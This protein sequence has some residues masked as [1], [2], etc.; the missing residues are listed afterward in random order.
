MRLV[1][2]GGLGFLGSNMICY[3]LSKYPSYKITNIDSVTYASNFD[4]LKEVENNPNYT[5]VKGNICDATLVDGLVKDSDVVI[6]FAA[7]SHVDRS[8]TGPGIF[9]QTNVVGTQVLLDACIKYNKHLHQIGTD[10]TM[11]DLPLNTPEKFTE[12]T[13]YNPSSPYS[14][15]KAA[16]DHLVMAY[17]RTYGLKCTLSGSS[18]NYGMKQH[19]EKL[20]PTIITNAMQGKNI[21]V[22]GDGKNVRDWVHTL[23]HAFA[24]DLII[25]RGKSGQRYLIGGN[26]ERSNLEVVKQILNI[27]GKPES[28]ISH[29][30][31]RKGHDLRYAVDASKIE[32]ELGW[33]RQYTFDDGIRETIA[34][35][36]QHA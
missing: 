34:W 33:S 12:N 36:L 13:P 21:P 20:I 17:H 24:I 22:Y 23:D 27:M 25:H 31:D 30:T 8:I 4:N 11:G 9:V 7:E 5:F 26:A 6:N 2:T 14:A 29:V 1:I 28:L 15:S 18:N 16:A 32:R 19:R 3:L 10:E 35:Y